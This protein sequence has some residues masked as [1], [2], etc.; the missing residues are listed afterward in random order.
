MGTSWSRDSLGFQHENQNADDCL[1]IVTIR[2]PFTWMKSMC[3]IPYSAIWDRSDGGTGGKDVCPHLAYADGRPSTEGRGISP[4]ALEYKFS[5]HSLSYDSLAHLWNEWYAGYWR[6]ADFPFLVV[7]MEDL[8][9]RQYE[10]TRIIC[11]YAGGMFPPEESFRYIVNSAKT[12]PA[13]GKVAERTDMIDAW[14][15]Y[16]KPMSAKA[17]FSDLDY[18]AAV[19]FLSS[20]LMEKMGYNYP[21]SE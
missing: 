18:K 19:K 17:E 9:F 5:G 20:E 6:D 4:V 10:T 15:K 8:V 11:D 2:N 21:P 3:K 7:R 1:P 14:V 12:G 16:G 13:H